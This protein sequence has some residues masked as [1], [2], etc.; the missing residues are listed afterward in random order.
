MRLALTDA[1]VR[2][3]KPTDKQ[4]KVWD[5]KTRGFGIRING[6]TKTWVVMY[7]AKRTL[8][9][10]GRYPD[11]SLAAAR[12]LALGYLATK[13][14]VVVSPKFEA[15]A[16]TFI[17]EHYADKSPRWKLQV[18]RL[19]GHFAE[20]NTLS[21]ADIT[22]RQ[23]SEELAKL[24]ETPSEKLHAFRVI[25][26]FFR[27]CVKP[28]RRYLT[29]SPLEGYE[30]PGKDR[31]GTRTLSDSELVKVW[32]ASTDR[33]GILI[34]LI[35]LWGTR[36][37]ETGRLQRPWLQND[38]L[39]IP[40]EYTKNGRAHAIPVLPMARGLL[41]SLP[42]EG[43]YYF[44]GVRP[45]THLKDGSWGKLKQQLDQR[46][47]INEPWQVRDLRRTFRS[48]MAKLRVSREVAEKLVNHVSEETNV[49]D[50]IYNQYDFLDE[51]REALAKYEAYIGN[52]LTT[53][54]A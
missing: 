4:T 10:L 32:N 5:T 34:K 18:A 45:G 35:I 36:G 53:H 2:A 44:P 27:W 3:L 46:T 11:V 13:P 47:G 49:L 41:E 15:A 21:L 43:I 8:K 14:E 31:K 28:P 37:G 9:T 50:V 29:R 6:H 12:Q 33:F 7:G 24:D 1:S 54:A 19:M 30:P 22:D 40:G 42:D 20:F 38:V 26:T 51:K 23:V 17:E 39:T 52:L 48:N 25:R 16:K